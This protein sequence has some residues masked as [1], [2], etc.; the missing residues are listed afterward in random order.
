M[1][2]WKAIFVLFLLAAPA[3]APAASAAAAS[4]AG[5]LANYQTTFAQIGTSLQ[6]SA[7]PRSLSTASSAEIA[8]TLNADESAG[9]P[10][11]TGGGQND[12]SINTSRVRVDSVK[13][14]EISSFSAIVERSKRRFPLLPPFVEIPY[15][16]TLVGYPLSAAKEFHSSTAILS[17]VG[18]PTSADIAFGLRFVFDLVVDGEPGEC[19]YIKGAGGK[20]AC[21]FRKALSMKDLN[22]EPVTAFNKKM[23]G[24]LAMATSKS[25]CEKLSFDD[26]PRDK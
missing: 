18:V 14:F 5:A 22:R 7:I 13:L 17:A 12:P 4:L 1:Q 16:G 2:N 19:S 8:V 25:E 6:F 20:K 23:V 24:C 10:T 21:L 11:Y 9:G 15:I 26:L 3:A